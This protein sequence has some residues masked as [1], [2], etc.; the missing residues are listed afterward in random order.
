MTPIRT[1]SGGPASTIRRSASSMRSSSSPERARRARGEDQLAAVG[2]DVGAEEA[3]LLLVGGGRLD[4][5]RPARRSARGRAA[6]AR[7]R[8]PARRCPRSAGTR[9]SRC[10]APAA[11]GR[12]AR[13]RA[14]RSR[15]RRRPATGSGAQSRVFRRLR[16]GARRAPSAAAARP[17]RA[18]PRQPAGSAAAAA[19]LTTISPAP[20]SL[21]HPHDLGGRGGPVTSSSRWE[22][23]D[24]EQVVLGAVHARPTCAAAMPG[25]RPRRSRGD[26]R[27]SPAHRDRAAAAPARRARRRRTAA[28]ARRRRTSAAR[29]RWRT[30]RASSRSKQP[31]IASA[32]CSAPSRPPRRA[33]RS[34][35][36]VKPETSTNT[37]V[38]STCGPCLRRLGEVPQQH[39]GDVRVEAAGAVRAAGGHVKRLGGAGAPDPQASRSRRGEVTCT[40]DP[41]QPERRNRDRSKVGLRRRCRSSSAQAPTRDCAGGALRRVLVLRVGALGRGPREASR[42]RK[43]RARLLLAVGWRSLQATRPP[44]TGNNPGN[45]LSA[46]ASN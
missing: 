43:G 26:S 36:F 17:P 33:S 15:A 44:A 19:L 20:A 45:K 39:A 23:A 3:D 5:R 28:A 21:L 41:T 6:G 37:T 32:S 31:P 40:S 25:R 11:A 34:D 29:R 42:S 46:T 8:R 7:S 10:G 2:V 18:A 13:A 12:P 38:A 1:G 35:S 9:P 22:L 24:G 30:R 27:S 16:R 4:G 14:A